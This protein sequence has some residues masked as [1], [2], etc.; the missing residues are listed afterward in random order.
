MF[1]QMKST[2]YLINT[3]RGGVIEKGA[4]LW[5]LENG[6]IKGAAVDFV[7]DPQLL[8]YAKIHSNLILTP[9]LGGATFED[10]SRTEEFIINKVLNYDI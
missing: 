1:S 6:I 5:A 7:D 2:A 8:Q 9:H 3:S 4:L 10:M